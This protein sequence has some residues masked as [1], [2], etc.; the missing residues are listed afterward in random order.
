MEEVIKKTRKK[1]EIPI[2]SNV[3]GRGELSEM[4]ITLGRISST[5]T[6]TVL[7]SDSLISTPF[8]EFIPILNVLGI[9]C[10]MTDYFGS[11]FYQIFYP[12]KQSSTEN[13]SSAYTKYKGNLGGIIG[14]NITSRNLRELKA[15][16]KQRLNNYLISTTPITFCDEHR[17]WCSRKEYILDAFKGNRKWGKFSMRTYTGH[18][19][20]LSITLTGNSTNYIPHV[21]GVT[22]PENFMYHKYKVLKDS[23]LDLSK[24]IV[25]VDRELDSPQFYCPAFRALYKKEI[26]PYLLS[27]SCQIWKVPL[28]FIKEKCFLQPFKLSSRNIVQRKEEIQE[29]AKEFLENF[30]S[31][32][33]PLNS[34]IGSAAWRAYSE[35]IRDLN[36]APRTLQMQVSSTFEEEFNRAIRDLGTIDYEEVREPQGIV[37]DAYREGNVFHYGSNVGYFPSNNSDAVTAMGMAMVAAGESEPRRTRRNRA[38]VPEYP[39]LDEPEVHIP[40]P[41][42]VVEEEDFPF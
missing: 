40:E 28:D 7:G 36:M 35:V 26:E 21:L 6:D 34:E 37:A 33:E 2:Y 4:K 38:V 12:K 30:S 32:D 41:N 42:R 14:A 29:L 24:V 25:L 19:S 10:S 31:K 3:A 5:N 20:H 16:I 9:D 11:T 27:T 17:H 18:V 1:K 8:S 39:I 15:D 23:S 13:V 22:L